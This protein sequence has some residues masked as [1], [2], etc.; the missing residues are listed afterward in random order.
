M[1]DHNNSE[2]PDEGDSEIAATC[3]KS[4]ANFIFRLALVPVALFVVSVLAYTASLFGD[5][6][7]PAHKWIVNSIEWI[8]S[9]EVL[10]SV[11]LCLLAM[12]DDR[13]RTTEG[14]QEAAKK[15]LRS[16]NSE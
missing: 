9:A 7:A 12:A 1:S 6:S 14:R 16:F 4:P 5:P 13:R 2:S 10:A 8:L 11:L 3:E 15:S